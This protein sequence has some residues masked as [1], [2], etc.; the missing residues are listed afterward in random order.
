MGAGVDVSASVGAGADSVAA[1]VGAG[2]CVLV[3]HCS[4]HTD[5]HHCILREGSE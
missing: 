4:Y 1:G 5:S 3:G 2:D